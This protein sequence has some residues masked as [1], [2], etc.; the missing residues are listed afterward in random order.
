MSL[1]VILSFMVLWSL[2]SKT[3]VASSL[4]RTEVLSVMCKLSVKADGR[5]TTNLMKSD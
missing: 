1:N 4:C 3:S 2:S 5:F